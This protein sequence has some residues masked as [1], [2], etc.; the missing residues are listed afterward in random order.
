MRRNTKG[1]KWVATKDNDL[2]AQRPGP[3]KNVTLKT[4]QSHHK[5]HA[6]AISEERG[7][8]ETLHSR[9]QSPT[10]KASIYDAADL[11]ELPNTYARLPRVRSWSSLRSDTYDDDEAVSPRTVTP[12]RKA[13]LQSTVSS[14]H[15]DLPP[16]RNSS[17]SAVE[18]IDFSSTE[19]ARK[20]S[21]ATVFPSFPSTIKRSEEKAAD[22]KGITSPGN[23]ADMLRN[24]RKIYDVG[25][26][27][28]GQKLWSTYKRIRK[29]KPNH[30][31]VTQEPVKQTPAPRRPSQGLSAHPPTRP[32]PSLDRLPLRRAIPPDGT[33]KGSEM[34]RS[35]VEVPIRIENDVEHVVDRARPLP[36]VP[37][38][39]AAPKLR[40]PAAT[41]PLP[42]LPDMKSIYHAPTKPLPAVPRTQTAP[43]R[44]LQEGHKHK[45]LAALIG[46][47][48]SESTNPPYPTDDRDQKLSQATP[49]AKSNHIIKPSQ[50]W[51]SLAD[52]T[53][54][55]H[56]PSNPK[57]N[58]SRPR[59]FTVL[60]NGLTANL[61][62]E[63]GGVGGPSAASHLPNQTAILPSPDNHSSSSSGLSDRALGK[64]K[65]PPHTPLYLPKHW[66]EKLH[67]ER[68]RSSDDLSFTCVGVGEGGPSR[69]RQVTGA[70]SSAIG[71]AR[72][73]EMVPEPLF[74]GRGR[75]RDTQFY[76]FYGEV[77]DEYRE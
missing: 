28:E 61:A 52:F 44:R 14:L 56:I 48:D 22:T 73:K 36:L 69:A 26:K 51:K 77:L 53:S 1:T 7:E 70:S 74:N 23:I 76:G 17:V 8:G 45:D 10:L 72:S 54:E 40:Q 57:A 55:T 30:T 62:A 21:N 37:K 9:P 27:G 11:R 50:W 25:P 75:G 15:T 33:R 66:R 71:S 42:A 39:A 46:F 13:S 19:E 5:S 63:H 16:W 29:D 59:P 35:S 38:L 60:Q 20:G 31:E 34:S 6:A 67:V 58:I 3:S 68:R 2:I 43:K 41:K 47:V 18:P 24:A 64:Q 12:L 32:A 49:P 65:L 4:Q